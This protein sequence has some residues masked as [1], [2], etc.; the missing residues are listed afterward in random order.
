MMEYNLKKIHSENSFFIEGTHALIEALFQDD[1][2]ESGKTKAELPDIWI[3]S[4]DGVDEL[5]PFLRQIVS[6]RPTIIFGKECHK[7]LLNS[8]PG[9]EQMVF[10]NLK[11][12]PDRA[13]DRIKK[14]FIACR[15]GLPVNPVSFISYPA[16]TLFERNVLTVFMSGESISD[17]SFRTGKSVNAISACK[18]RIMRKL[19]VFNNQELFA[20]AW[21][22]GIH[23]DA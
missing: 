1:F 16:L 14:A 17:F 10:L 11:I 5:Y 23:F 15:Y 8:V 6:H 12:S 9:L 4:R 13:G 22:M 20:K 19:Y 7:R 2:P 3:F 18:R 21:A